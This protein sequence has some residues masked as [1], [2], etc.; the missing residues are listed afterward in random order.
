MNRRGEVLLLGLLLLAGP[1]L[2]QP[3]LAQPA[4][5]AT[6]DKEWPQAVR[7]LE[8]EYDE[9]GFWFSSTYRGPD[10]V[11][12]LRGNFDLDSAR[13]RMEFLVSQSGNQTLLTMESTLVALLEY[14][15]VGVENRYELSDELVQRI[16]I[17]SLS[18]ARL[19]VVP[20]SPNG[21]LVVAEFP[22]Q[23]PPQGGP[24][25]V[26]DP[27]SGGVVQLRFHIYPQP[28]D[29]NGVHLNA[30]DVGLT[31]RLDE[32][33]RNN[34][35]TH[36][37]V[38]IETRGNG[39][40]E[41]TPNGVVQGL[42]DFQLRHLWGTNVYVD[43]GSRPL[44]VTHLEAS[45]SASIPPEVPLTTVYSYPV[46]DHV[47]H[48]TMYGVVHYEAPPPAMVPTPLV[49]GDW[50]VYGGGILLSALIVGGS[51]FLRLRRG[52]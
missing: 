17:R 39:P 33:P 15:N 26:G 40:F 42:G 2:T 9:Q 38:E 1:F 25:P 11:D 7:Q 5:G 19:V 37:A 22:L 46:G 8:F 13:F 4:P 6:A 16:P 48:E 21:Y 49:F 24:L 28:E 52:P 45:P 27:P 51:A 35:S 30:T 10:G 34:T 44:G 43:Q 29:L 14:R 47:D 36:F 32:I 20:Q 50:Q 31:I 23:P 18:S 3:A 41:P 12:E